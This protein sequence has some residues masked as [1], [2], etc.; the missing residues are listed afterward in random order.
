MNLSTILRSVSNG[1]GF[2]TATRK[3]DL[4][5]SLATSS[6]T[7]SCSSENS[8]FDP[9]SD[10]SLLVPSQDEEDEEDEE[11]EAF[12]LGENR[13]A[14][15]AASLSKDQVVN[16]YQQTVQQILR[17]VNELEHTIHEDRQQEFKLRMALDRQ[18]ERV[19]ELVFSLDTEK[20]RNGRLVQLL[21]G[22]DSSSSAESDPEE[23]RPS[24]SHV[25]SIGELYDSIS[26]LLM[27]QRYDELSVSHRQS[28]RQLAKREKA[29]KVLKCETEELHSKYDELFD[30]YRSEQR[31]FEMLC[32]RYIQ[33]QLKKKQQIFNLKNTLGQASE[34]IFHAQVAID[35]CCHAEKTPISPEHLENFRRNLECFMDALR[36]CCC[37]RKVHELQQQQLKKEQMG[38]GQSQHQNP[39]N[40]ALTPRA[41]DPSS[42]SS[43]TYVHS[44]SNRQPRIRS[45][46]HSAR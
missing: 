18:T 34:C 41:K 45:H 24:G 10:S 35:E 7:S 5:R 38:R 32:T 21:R 2:G 39:D 13:L 9:V 17:L 46:R 30:E 42:S 29:L 16:P 33:M 37:L 23:I 6:S 11:D 40:D 44:C 3:G 28:R 31:R 20:K 36:N 8:H 4:G 25:N 27:Q 22:I 12:T 1:L 26:P 14:S 19:Q 43:G 15:A